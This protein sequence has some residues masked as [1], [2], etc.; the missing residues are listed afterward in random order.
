MEQLC[1]DECISYS[2]WGVLIAMLVFRRVGFSTCNLTIQCFGVTW[3]PAINK[4]NHPGCLRTG[5]EK[6]NFR[7]RKL[8]IPI[9]MGT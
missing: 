4:K 3:S 5:Y 6:N 2:K 7:R 9:I 8:I 1:E